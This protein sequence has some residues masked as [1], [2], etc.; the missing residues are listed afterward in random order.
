MYNLCC[1]SNIFSKT[2]FLNLE[3][4]LKD[5]IEKYNTDISLA[6]L[7]K[8]IVLCFLSIVHSDYFF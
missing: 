1:N 8:Q 4:L 6:V 7:F 2:P 5:I 3:I